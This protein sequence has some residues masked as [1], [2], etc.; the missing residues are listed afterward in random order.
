MVVENCKLNIENLGE[1]LGFSTT[2]RVEGTGTEKSL[3][4]CAICAEAEKIGIRRKR[5]RTVNP[6]IRFIGG[7]VRETGEGNKIR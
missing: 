4:C 3:R 5:I 6:V 7:I 1:N 2:L